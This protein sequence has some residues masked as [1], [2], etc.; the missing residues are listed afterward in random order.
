VTIAIAAGRLQLILEPETGGSVGAFTLARPDGQFDLMRPLS[1][2]DHAL[3]SGMFPML[4]FANCIRDNVFV[5]GGRHYTVTPNMKGARLNFHGSG[6]LSAW[7]ADAV[8]ETSAEL[9]LADGR[10]DEVYRFEASQRFEL[11][12]AGLTV[13]LAVVNRGQVA[14]PFGFGLHPW[15]PTHG[16]ARIAFFAGEIIRCDSDGQLVARAAVA[17]G[18]SYAEL[19]RPPRAYLNA[20]YA[21]WNGTA[22]VDWLAAGVRLNMRA[23]PVFRH[24]M[25]HV[26][27]NAEA[28]VCLEPQSNAP[29]PFEGIE[30]GGELHGVSVL[31]PGERL[32]TQRPASSPLSGPGMPGTSSPDSIEVRSPVPSWKCWKR[33]YGASTTAAMADASP[34][35]RQSPPRPSAAAIPSARRSRRWSSPAC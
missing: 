17:D 27:S 13:T 31:Q 14:M 12:P 28:V 23:D 34:A 32:A 21:D 2:A 18:D 10:V 5:F 26:P 7:E 33:C 15:F 24:L 1:G 35:T 16:D 3:R 22:A 9:R 25:V 4:P 11:D 30:S 6:W 20:C 8:T 19:R 29:C